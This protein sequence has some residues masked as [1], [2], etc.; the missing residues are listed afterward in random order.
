MKYLGIG[1]AE[2]PTNNIVLNFF[3]EYKT[4]PSRPSPGL[5][6]LIV[7][8]QK[9]MKSINLGAISAGLTQALH[10]ININSQ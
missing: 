7:E 4:I 8:F 10:Q 6:D 3:P 2:I 9:Q 1:I 5:T